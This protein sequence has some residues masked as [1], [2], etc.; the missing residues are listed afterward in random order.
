MLL[1][2]CWSDLFSQRVV[3]SNFKIDSSRAIINY[4]IRD[5]K[6]EQTFFVGLFVSNDGGI[7]FKGPL[8]EV[9]GDVGLLKNNYGEKTIVWDIFSETDELTGNVVFEVRAE[10][11]TNSVK[12]GLLVSYNYTPTAP[13]GLRLGFMGNKGAYLSLKSNLNFTGSG[14]YGTD[15]NGLNNYTG[16]G[17]W[18]I[19]EN[20]VQNRYSATAGYLHKFKRNLIFYGGAGYCVDEILWEYDEYSFDNFNKINTDYALHTSS[21][22]KSIEIEAG[23]IVKI[24]KFIILGGVSS[25]GFKYVEPNIGGGFIF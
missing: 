17:Y 5:W 15:N 7:N 20:S 23:L 6:E 10:M 8:R 12:K 4:K 11:K 25:I 16:N 19:K 1:N 2:F 18:I 13:V 14:L 22:I 21:A 24:R 9:S 3:S